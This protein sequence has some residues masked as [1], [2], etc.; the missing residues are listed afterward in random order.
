MNNNYIIQNVFIINCKI[1]NNKTENGSDSHD[2]NY[3]NEENEGKSN[4]FFTVEI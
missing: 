3:K 4:A 1:G 2:S